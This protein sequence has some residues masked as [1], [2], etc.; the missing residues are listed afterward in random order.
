RSERQFERSLDEELV[1]QG[2]IGIQGVDTRAITRHLRERGAMKAGIFSGE[3]AT[4][5]VAELLA[6]V[7]AQASMEGQQLA[8]TVSVQDAYIVEPK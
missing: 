7:S 8:D 5:P 3:S 6:E 2:I 1:A 4:R